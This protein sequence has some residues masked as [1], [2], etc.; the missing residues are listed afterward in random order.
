[1][2]GDKLAAKHPS[3]EYKGQIEAIARAEHLLMQEI[4]WIA[5]FGA[6]KHA[7]SIWRKTLALPRGFY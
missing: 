7:G 3:N 5:C 2:M 1:M 6:V 4:A